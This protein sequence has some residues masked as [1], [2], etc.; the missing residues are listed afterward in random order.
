MGFRKLAKEIGND[1]IDDGK[2]FIKEGRTFLADN[3]S[4]LDSPR[5]TFPNPRPIPHMRIVKHAVTDANK[6]P[7]ARTW[8]L[9]IEGSTLYIAAK[10]GILSK[11]RLEITDPTTWPSSETYIAPTKVNPA[12]LYP[13][14]KPAYT[15][16]SR[17][18]GELSHAFYKKNQCPLGLSKEYGNLR[19]IQNTLTARISEREINTC[20]LL[21][22][23]PH[24]NV[25]IYRGVMSDTELD[26]DFRGTE[27]HFPL[28][29]ERVISVVF[30]KYTCTLWNMVDEKKRFDARKRLQDV[31]RGIEH[32]HRLGIAHCDIKPDN[33][34]VDLSSTSNPIFVLGNFDSAHHFGTVYDLKGGADGWSRDKRHARDVVEA[35]DDWYSFQVVK[36]WLMR[37][38]GARKRDLEGIGRALGR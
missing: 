25:A 7:I 35:D 6:I 22:A 37:E 15:R 8:V 5:A 23:N 24:P 27:V 17:Q 30:K 26:F 2:N 32:F 11:S 4:I 38:T 9:A 13:L 19:N 3:R 16:Y 1:F 14:M 34:F 20:E 18:P 12:N 36:E 29:R 10:K 21:R 31:A 33:I 28:D